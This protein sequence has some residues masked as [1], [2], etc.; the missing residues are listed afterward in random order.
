[1]FLY[2][3]KIA[4]KN[5]SKKAIHTK[6][7]IVNSTDSHLESYYDCWNLHFSSSSDIL[8]HMPIL[9]H[10]VYVFLNFAKQIPQISQT[11]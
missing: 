2:L 7:N 6:K 8:I 5:V 3:N 4:L 10:I 11:F 1:M 9:S